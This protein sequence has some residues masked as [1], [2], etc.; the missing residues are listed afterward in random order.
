MY[1]QIHNKILYALK[2]YDLRKGSKEATKDELKNKIE[3]IERHPYVKEWKVEIKKIKEN[4]LKNIPGNLEIFKKSFETNVKHLFYAK[5]YA[6]VK[7]FIEEITKDS[8]II[9]KSKSLVGEE[10]E[11][12]QFLESLGKKVYETDLGEF[13]V[14]LINGK[15]AHMVTPAVNMTEKKARE[16]LGKVINEKMNDVTSMVLAVRKFMREKFFEADVGIIGANALSLDGDIIFIT[17]EGNGA[18]SSILPNKLIVITSIE[19][20]YPSLEDALK[21]CIIQTVYAG[22]K[23]TSYIHIINGTGHKFGP[24]EIYIILMDNGRTR[25]DFLKETLF[26]IKCGSCQ[27]SCPIFYEI[28]GVWGYIYTAAIG[29]PWTALTGNVKMA[30]E[31]SYYCLQCGRCKEVCPMEIDIPELII[32]IKKGF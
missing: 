14:Q 8:K 26:C 22:F 32:K 12:R 20:I 28:D 3:S 16:V 9:V 7:K 25:D 2:D 4:M 19:K 18:L 30:K 13:L 1:N 29:I 23:N 27:L 31:L 11:L 21:A 5:S 24:K 17:N 15:P 6:D 10:I